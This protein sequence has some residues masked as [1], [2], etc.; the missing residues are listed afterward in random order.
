MRWSA[1]CR[2]RALH[3]GRRVYEA[4]MTPAQ[5]RIA[6]ID[7]AL[8]SAFVSD[9]QKDKLLDERLKLMAEQRKA[10]DTRPRS[11]A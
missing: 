3:T 7:T 4:G 9:V 11:A 1:Q 2:G 6:D 8:A 5:Q 10:A